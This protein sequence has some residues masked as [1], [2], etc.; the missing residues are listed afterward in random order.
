MTAAERPADDL[1]RHDELPSSSPGRCA[2][3]S[4]QIADYRF[5]KPATTLIIIAMIE[6]PNTNDSTA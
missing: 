1:I 6:V 2:A 3:P 5:S 4:G